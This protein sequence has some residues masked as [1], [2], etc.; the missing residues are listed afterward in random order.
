[1]KAEK[2]QSLTFNQL[3][4]LDKKASQEANG[5]KGNLVLRPQEIEPFVR[6][7]LN[8]ET[9][10][11]HLAVAALLDG[12]IG[13]ESDHIILTLRGVKKALE[14][15]GLS[16]DDIIVKRFSEASDRPEPVALKY[17]EFRYEQLEQEVAAIEEAIKTQEETV[18]KLTER[19]KH[20]A[21]TPLAKLG[22]KV[23]IFETRFE[24]QLVPDPDMKLR[25]ARKIR[26][27][28]ERDRALFVADV[29]EDLDEE[30][31]TLK[32][33]REAHTK[34]QGEMSGLNV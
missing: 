17:N 29:K 26:A 2:V 10:Q 7:I 12:E 30:T 27:L 9:I 20:W 16:G 32:R 4:Q 19:Y 5:N 21:E 6:R 22:E 31:D 14:L 24:I 3:Y 18:G 13:L 15:H 8:I 34:R 11:P 1:P 25:K 23:G 33:M 28:Q